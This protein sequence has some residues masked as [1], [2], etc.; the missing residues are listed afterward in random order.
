MMLKKKKKTKIHQE[1]L[2][3]KLEG[4]SMVEKAMAIFDH[5]LSLQTLANYS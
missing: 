2:G 1:V 5:S 3:A 4:G